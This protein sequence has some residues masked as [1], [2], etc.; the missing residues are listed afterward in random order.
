LETLRLVWRHK[1]F[2][3]HGETLLFLLKSLEDFLMQV[4]M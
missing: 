2:N 4:E 1:D 3:R